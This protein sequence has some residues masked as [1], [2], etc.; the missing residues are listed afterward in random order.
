MNETLRLEASRKLAE[1]LIHDSPREDVRLSLLGNLL[2]SRDWQPKEKAVLESE[3]TQFRATYSKNP[4]D[5]VK[6]LHVGE[7]KLD[8]SIPAPE[9]AA[10]MLVS[11]TALNLDAVINK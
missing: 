3:L 5:A 6:L 1:R 11:S 7:S 4:A 8:H 9:L 10:W 2:L